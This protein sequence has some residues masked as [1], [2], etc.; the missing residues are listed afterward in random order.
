[1]NAALVLCVVALV[2]PQAEARPLALPTRCVEAVNRT[3]AQWRFNVPPPDAAEW[4]KEER[5]NPS[6]TRADLNADGLADFAALLIANNKPQLV[7]C[8]GRKNRVD[9]LVVE[10]PYCSD[11]VYRS[12]AGKRYY[13]FETGKHGV[14]RRDGVSVSCFGKSGATY[15]IEKGAVQKIVDSD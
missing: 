8:L 14:L 7:L 10:Q 1:M 13:N 6:V 3:F 15:V 9:L 4:A 5:L 2:S 11:V 12:R